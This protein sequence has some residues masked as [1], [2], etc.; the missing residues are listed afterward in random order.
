MLL[1]AW[2][3]NDNETI[4]FLWCYWNMFWLLIR[5]SPGGTPRAGHTW[6]CDSNRVVWALPNVWRNGHWIR[7]R[8]DLRSATETGAN[9]GRCFRTLRAWRPEPSETMHACRVFVLHNMHISLDFNSIDFLDMLEGLGLLLIFM[10]IGIWRDFIW[11]YY[12]A[13][14]TV[15]LCPDDTVTVWCVHCMSTVLLATAHVLFE[16]YQGKCHFTLGNAT[17]F[18]LLYRGGFS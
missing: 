2:L 12:C 7:K 9:T 18:I 1:F 17:R 15:P 16:T 10:H 3:L 8:S 6:V 5:P 11:N 4:E 14:A 13:F